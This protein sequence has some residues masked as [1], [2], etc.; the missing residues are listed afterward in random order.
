MAPMP[1]G[2][3]C[4]MARPRMRTSRT[5]SARRSAPAATSAEYSPSEWPATNCASRARS[6]PGFGF[7]HP[8]RRE[9]DRHQ[10]RLRV[11]GERQLLRRPFP[12]DRAEPVAERGVDL[13]EYR[14]GGGK[15]V[16]QRLAHA[17]G[18]TAL[19]WKHE[20]DRHFMPFMKARRQTPGPFACQA[21]G[22]CRSALIVTNRKPC[23][24]TGKKPCFAKVVRSTWSKSGSPMSIIAL[25]TDA[26]LARARLDPDI[27]APIGGREPRVPA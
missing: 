23:F 20:C 12:H 5:A 22:Y 24:L 25:V 2:T 3:A 13:I 17:D 10:R 11:L 15:G 16:G 27:P 19:P 8:H 14:A 26:E 18:L 21:A 9:R 6:T 7:Q 4:C 1:T